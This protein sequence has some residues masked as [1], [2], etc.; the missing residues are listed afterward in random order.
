[1]SPTMHEALVYVGMACLIAG[2]F[3][4]IV[5]PGKDVDVVV[6]DHGIAVNPARPDLAR[7]LTDDGIDHVPID[8]LI[9]R[10]RSTQTRPRVANQGQPRV[11]IENRNGGILDLIRS[12]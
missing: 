1:M 4:C 12:P 5:T 6:T 11:V 10:A 2:G 7:R 9:A 3:A 8:A